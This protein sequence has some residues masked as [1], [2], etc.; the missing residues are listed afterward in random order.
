MA[1]NVLILPALFLQLLL[2]PGP[3]L[4]ALGA[5]VFPEKGCEQRLVFGHDVPVQGDDGNARL[6]C[7]PEHGL[8]AVLCN[9]AEHDRVYALRDKASEGLD[10]LVLELP[11]IVIHQEEPVLRRKGVLHG[12]RVCRA[13]GGLTAELGKAHGDKVLRR[14]RS[15]GNIRGNVERGAGAE[16]PCSQCKKQQEYGQLMGSVHDP[17]PRLFSPP[18]AVPGSSR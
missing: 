4:H 5:H 1:R 10:L 12:L 2:K 14:I 13:P 15:D 3:R 8:P 17:P 18:G 9:R 11:G 6:F 16:G 7:L